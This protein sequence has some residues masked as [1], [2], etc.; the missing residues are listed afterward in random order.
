MQRSVVYFGSVTSARNEFSTIIDDFNK[1]SR[2]LRLIDE[3]HFLNNRLV[4][5][6]NSTA[7]SE[8]RAA[9]SNDDFI[10]LLNEVIELRKQARLLSKESYN[11]HNYNYSKPTTARQVRLVVLPEEPGTPVDDETS[12]VIHYLNQLTEELQ[13]TD[14]VYSLYPRRGSHR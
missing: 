9:N 10:V 11:L 3:L 14:I 5:L 2:L 1:S 12:M 13:K 6:K 7:S 4:S 8:M